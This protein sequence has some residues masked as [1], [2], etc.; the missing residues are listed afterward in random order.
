[1]TES[2]P[3]FCKCSCKICRSNTPCNEVYIHSMPLCTTKEVYWPSI[4]LCSGSHGMVGCYGDTVGVCKA[5][6]FSIMRIA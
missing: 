5:G 4:H 1:M 3:D 2:R 6:L